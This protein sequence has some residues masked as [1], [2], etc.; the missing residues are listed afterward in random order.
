M[1]YDVVLIGGGLSSLVS[2]I[3][4]QRSGRKCLMVSAGQ[5]A[6]HFSS[7]SFG[8]LSRL[9]DGTPVERPLDEAESLPAGHP[10]SKIGGSGLRDLAGGIVPFFASCGVRLHGGVETN[11]WRL[12]PTGSMKPAALALDEVA[13]F[14]SKDYK[15]GH[16]AL[17][18]NIE[19]F[20]DFNSEFI[21]RGLRERGTDCRLETVS[22]P[23]TEHLRKNPTEMRS[24]NI[25]RVMDREEV[26][27]AFLFAVRS[28]LR[29]EDVIVMPEV[30]GFA[31]TS[32]IVKVSEAFPAT[33]LFV[34][35]VPPSVPGMRTQMLLKKAF[36]SSGGMLLPGDEVLGGEISD[37]RVKSILTVNLGSVSVEADDF[38]LSTGSFFGKGIVSGPGTVYEPVFGLDT[39]YET[40]RSKW[41]DE[42]FFA[43]QEYLSFGVDTDGRF[44]AKKG[45]KVIE[46]LY[47]T[48]SELSGANPLYEG[49]GAGIAIL[50]AMQVAREILNGN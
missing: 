21:A 31:D 15:I 37:G 12:T 20:L 17:I 47:V 9:P 36:E 14:P 32:A 6:L 18:V 25:A 45:G 34:G 33:V 50:S 10:Y 24:V 8:I 5:N 22:L 19:G 39:V 42:D 41:Y 11:G 43:R 2:G 46:N 13:L 7:G 4:L 49:S 38:I 3:I 27:T 23:E 28:L 48:G 40:D 29:G 16:K 35:T 30:F 1:R 44:R 26:R